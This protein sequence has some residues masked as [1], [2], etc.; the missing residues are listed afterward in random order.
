MRIGFGYDS[1]RLVEGRK[2]VLGGVEIPYEKGL[3]GHSDGDVL[4]HAII[5]AIFGALGVGDIGRHFPD[6]DPTNKD[7]VSVELLR[8]TVEYARAEG[9]EVNW[10]DST[11][12][13]EEPMLAPHVDAM[14]QALAVSKLHP[15]NISIKAKRNEGMG[16]IGRGE[17]VAAFAVCM[18]RK[19]QSV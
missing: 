13:I 8:R 17:G 6:T 16:F 14:R 19:L 9:Y 7:I 15:G 10:I 12:I 11:V 5:D 1:H 3:L 2:L 4:T 18:L